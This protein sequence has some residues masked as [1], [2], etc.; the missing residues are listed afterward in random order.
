MKSM[1]I[2]FVAH[3][4]APEQ[5]GRL[6]VYKKPFYLNREKLRELG[7]I[8]ITKG[9]DACF[10]EIKRLY[11][12]S[13]RKRRLCTIGFMLEGSKREYCFTHNLSAFD[14]SLLGK[15]NIYKEFKSFLLESGGK[16]ESSAT[17]ELGADYKVE[18]VK[19]HYQTADLSRPVKIYFRD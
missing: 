12:A 14:D 3:R 18:R 9:N 13:L 2:S 11:R 17:A 10:A 8:F 15:V 7:Y 1:G 19:K 4:Y 16:Y 6:H 5:F